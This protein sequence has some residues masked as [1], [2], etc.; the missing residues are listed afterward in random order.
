MGSNNL[1]PLVSRGPGRLL[2]CRDAFFQRAGIGGK[3]QER[4]ESTN[5]NSGI[6]YCGGKN[7]LFHQTSLLALLFELQS[8]TNFTLIWK[9]VKEK[10]DKFGMA[11]EPSYTPDEDKMYG[12]GTR[13]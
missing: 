1:F 10:Q 9:Q 2:F 11:K 7:E 4:S 5:C 13:S 6:A 8:N 12:L 3:K